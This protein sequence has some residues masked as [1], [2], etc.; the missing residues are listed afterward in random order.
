MKKYLI[1]FF[2]SLTSSFANA[3]GCDGK[4]NELGIYTNSG[5]VWLILDTQIK[6]WFIC[7][8]NEPYDN[9][10]AVIQADSCAALYGTLLAA[11]ATNSTVHFE[12]T[13][14]NTCELVP[15]WNALPHFNFNLVS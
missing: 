9:G 7:S 12:L 4:I 10:G 15:S 6:G 1:L 8:L 3:S 2:L 11:R 5:V 14:P 13:A